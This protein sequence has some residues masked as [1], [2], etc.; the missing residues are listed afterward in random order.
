MRLGET[1]TEERQVWLRAFYGFNPE[2]AGY[3]GFTRES[4]RQDMLGK[5]RDGDLVLIYGAVE[6][7]TQPDLR[8]QALGFM[9]IKLEKCRDTDRQNEASRA[10]KIE[11]GFEDRWTYGV[12]VVRAWRIRNRVRIGTIAPKAYRSENRFERTTKA[13]LL[14]SDERRRA[15]SHPVYQVNVYGEVPLAEED[16]AA[17]TMDEVLSPSRGIP[18]SFGNRASH[19]E[20]G[21]NYLYLMM[22]TAKAEALLGRAGPHVGKALVKIGRSNDPSRR[23]KEINGGFPNN[24]MCRWQLKYYQAFADG[25]TAHS[26]ENELKDEFV[27]QFSSQGKEFFCGDGDAT[28]RAFQAFCAS[29]I[30]KILAAAGRAKGVK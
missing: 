27:K 18:P 1:A 15:L 28:E 4:Q 12:K 29:K 26:H 6:G 24:A 21:E 17:S 3:L 30:P 10:W 20:D 11:H 2:E 16:L 19:H 23:L 9:E 25:T 13:I 22:L 8:S 7:L 5:M 14:E